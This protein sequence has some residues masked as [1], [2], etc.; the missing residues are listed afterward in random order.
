MA[1]K[2]NKP[3]KC[4]HMIR[5]FICNVRDGYFLVNGGRVASGSFKYDCH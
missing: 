1:C 3:G 5:L 4:C 2:I